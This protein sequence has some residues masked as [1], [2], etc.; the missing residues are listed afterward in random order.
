LAQHFELRIRDII[1]V[2]PTQRDLYGA[3]G[4]IVQKCTVVTHQNECTSVSL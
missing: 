2:Y 1:I 4:D 3:S